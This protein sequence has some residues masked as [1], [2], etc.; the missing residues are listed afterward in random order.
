MLEQEIKL[1]APDIQALDSVYE[2]DLLRQFIDG[3]SAQ[4]VRFLAICYDTPEHKL[5]KSRVSFRARLEGTIFRAAFKLPGQIVNGLSSRI[6]HET[7]IDGWLS[8][9]ESIPPGTL[10]DE[11]LKFV[12][13]NDTLIQKVKV[14]MQRR[15]MNLVVDGARIEVVADHGVISA[16]EKKH[17]LFEL[18]LE[19]KS[20][21]VDAIT[22]LG[23]QILEIYD[24]VPS[25]ISKH[26]IGL[27][28]WDRD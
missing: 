27:N 7:E 12:N 8:N 2:S 21:E 13:E 9:V 24:L 6:E 5:G 17:E 19:L 1:T 4:P 20:G 18:E 15:I 11:L 28:L 22:G 26:E 10:K 23:K 25:T 16:N 14:D 3:K